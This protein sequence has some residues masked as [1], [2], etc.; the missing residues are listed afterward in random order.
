MR[1]AWDALVWFMCDVPDDGGLS[2][3]RLLKVLFVF[4]L[5]A[6]V[7]VVPIVYW[8]DSDSAI[9]RLLWADNKLVMCIRCTS[10]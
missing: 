1:K 4:C 5:C 9:M 10:H 7:F 2:I 3:V 8:R 6:A